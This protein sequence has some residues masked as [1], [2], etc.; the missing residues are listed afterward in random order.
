MSLNCVDLSNHCAYK[1]PS[2]RHPI[3]L[4]A[5]HSHFSSLNRVFHEI[6]IAFMHCGWFISLYVNI[7]NQSAIYFINCMCIKSGFYTNFRNI[8]EIFNFE[9][10]SLFIASFM[11][12]FNLRKTKSIGFFLDEINFAKNFQNLFN[13]LKA[14]MVQ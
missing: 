6:I 3:E 13:H 4:T 8:K 12:C 9:T 1:I 2:Y 11:S 5:Q 10:N 7:F 14:W